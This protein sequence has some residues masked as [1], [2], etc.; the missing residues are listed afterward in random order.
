MITRWVSGLCKTFGNSSSANID[1]SET[2]CPKMAQ[3]GWF[4]SN[5]LM[6]QMMNKVLS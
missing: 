6:K 2:Q 1:L 4:L 3:F 5:L